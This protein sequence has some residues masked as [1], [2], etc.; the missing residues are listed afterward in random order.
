MAR[1]DLFATKVITRSHRRKQPFWRRVLRFMVKVGLTS[2]IAVLVAALAGFLAYEYITAP[3]KAWAQEFD[4]ERINDLEKPSI[5]YDRN[6]QEIGRIYIE[7]RSYVPL[8]KV[9]PHMVNALIAQEDSRFRQHKGFDPLGIVRAAIEMAKAGGK[10]NQGASSITQQLARNAYDLK[11]RSEERGMGGF[12][13]KI[14]EIFL[15]LRIEERYSKDQILEFYLNRVYFG[16]GNYGIRAASLGYFGKEPLELTTRES[17]SIAGLIKNPNNISPL[18]NPKNNLRWRNHVLDRMHLEGYLTQEEAAKLK[19]MPLGLNPKPLT[20]RISHIYDRI[21]SRLAS[22]I[23][24]ERTATGGLK[25]YT[26]LDKRIQDNALEA[27]NRSLANIENRPDYKYPKYRDYNINPLGGN[28]PEFIEGAV[29]MVE[30]STGAIL[31]YH[32]GRD[33]GKRQFDSIEMGKRSP[34]TALLPFVY[35]AGFKSGQ[36][37]ASRVQDDQ[38][39]NRTAGVGGS[40]G[41]LGE[42]GAEI[43]NPRYE[44]N[45]SARHALA[46]GKCAA[47]IRFGQKYPVNNLVDMLGQLGMSKPQA[48]E[49]G[50]YRPRT[51]IGFD[52]VSLKE[53]VKAYSAFAGM[54]TMVRDL[55]FLERI[56]SE[57][58]ELLWE[59]PKRLG[60]IPRDK[61]LDSGV[62]YQIN[63]VLSDSLKYGPAKKVADQFKKSFLGVAATGTTYTFSDNWMVGYNDKITCGVWIGHLE[64]GKQIY[65]GAFSSETCGPVLA[66]AINSALPEYSGGMVSMPD[67]LERIEICQTS[68]KRAGRYCYEIDRNASG[69][70]TRY[71]RTTYFE[72]LRKG[73]GSVA[74]CDVHL[75]EDLNFDTLA[76]ILGSTSSSNNK[77]LPVAPIVPKSAVLLGNDTYQSQ[78]LVISR[79]KFDQQQ[80]EDGQ[81]EQNLRPRV[82]VLAN[83]ED[84]EP[85]ELPKLPDFDFELPLISNPQQ[86]AR[87]TPSNENTYRETGEQH[88]D[89]S[90]EEPFFHPLTRD[91]DE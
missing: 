72:F 85:I 75:D 86:R 67:N 36:S 10:A 42:W 90:R 74:D 83:N 30:N 48:D 55:Y 25:I 79:Y 57:R 56:E 23:G 66:S 43:T 29:L 60:T 15:A 33:F 53:M 77:I 3:F 58:G 89:D 84:N 41:V 76:G 14:V 47:T 19:D 62:C 8:S 64:N 87:T 20:R 69:N 52:P 65:N 78:K 4:L 50:V 54:G 27:L 34:G 22:Y 44:G 82:V 88:A 5:I 13:R 38:I 81:Q 9:S 51:Y 45:I 35:A 80:Q 7:N 49:H 46:K 11:K 2:V 68:G 24:T 17:A 31:A 59:S 1:Q 71:R 91:N 63:S 73:D 32:G 37:P 61:V 40:E 21:A 12:G 16:S 26:T 18:N 70:D 39:D 28:K 6:N